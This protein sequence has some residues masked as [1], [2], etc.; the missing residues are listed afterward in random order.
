[1]EY[2][3]N[4][5]N[6]EESNLFLRAFWSQLR[7]SSGTYGWNFSPYKDSKKKI[8]NFGCLST[9]RLSRTYNFKIKYKVRGVIYKLIVES[10][11]NSNILKQ[12]N[13]IIKRAIDVAMDYNSLL[14]VTFTYLNFKTS[15]YA[16]NN[17]QSNLFAIL[18]CDDNK[19]NLKIK[20][21]GFD[22]NDISIESLKKALVLKDFLSTQTSQAIYKTE[23][24]APE[25][26]NRN[27][28]LY[29]D[30]PWIDDYPT[31]NKQLLLSHKAV[32]AIDLI[33]SDEINENLNKF[34][35]AS[36]L[37]N[38]ACKYEILAYKG[39]LIDL[40]ISPQEISNILF[41]SSLEVLSDI[42]YERNDVCKSCNREIFSIRK[43][44][45]GLV[46]NFSDGYMDKIEID[47]Y[48]KIRSSYV[49]SGIFLSDRSYTSFSHPQLS[50]GDSGFIS[51]VPMINLL[52]LRETIGYIFRNILDKSIIT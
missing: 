26:Q 10:L 34:I 47:N 5:N 29:Y 1:M 40:D 13:I 3:I 18:N 8:I 6:I 27:K 28:N 46:E 30:K 22:S 49:H 16:I 21:K 7:E 44:V 43:K 51:Q 9:S 38:I 14:N 33:I 11:D 4:L 37:Y 23:H 35:K 39:T 2:I 32:Q 19:F 42:I 50:K 12:D 20:V 48:Y 41:M 52:K 45:L 24:P 36:R 15:G 25:F 31:N 17:T